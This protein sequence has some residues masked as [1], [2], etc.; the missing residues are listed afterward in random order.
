MP[1]GATPAHSISNIP[2][3]SVLD[4]YV[5]I[6]QPQVR[7]MTAAVILIGGN[8]CRLFTLLTSL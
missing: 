2:K 1:H 3:N 8:H 7:S 4:S 6:K 5:R